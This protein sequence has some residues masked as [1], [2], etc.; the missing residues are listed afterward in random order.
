MA[1]IRI[2]YAM[3]NPKLIKYMNDVKF[4]VNSYTMNSIT[5]VCGA[6]AVKDVEYFNSTTAKII[7][8]REYSKKKLSG[9]GFSFQDSMSNFI[10]ATHNKYKACNIFEDLK[11]RNIFVRYF[12]KPRINN[13]LR[14]SVGT[15]E[16]MD[17]LFKAL[18]EIFAEYERN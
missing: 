6:E 5:Q 12:N 13:Y 3:G 2:G 15:P 9:L 18:S 1:G 7:E 14:I 17:R 8:T 16:E 4:S 11:K 10:F